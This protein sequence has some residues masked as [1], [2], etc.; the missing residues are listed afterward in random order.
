[1][2]Q[3]ISVKGGLIPE[4]SKNASR[5]LNMMFGKVGSEIIEAPVTAEAFKDA[6]DVRDFPSSIRM[7][8]LG[9][10]HKPEQA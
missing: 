1:M 2:L 8:N 6:D 7:F 9:I 4:S 5:P 3:N 10:K